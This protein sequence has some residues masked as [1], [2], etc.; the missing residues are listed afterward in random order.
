MNTTSNAI[1]AQATAEGT[2]PATVD[3]TVTAIHLHAQLDNAA[4]GAV[5][6]GKDGKQARESADTR[7][8]RE[9]RQYAA[10]NRLNG[11]QLQALRAG[12]L[13]RES[14]ISAAYDALP[15]DMGT[16]DR[17]TMA[18]GNAISA[19]PTV[20]VT[21]SDNERSFTYPVYLALCTNQQ[22]LRDAAC[23]AIAAQAIAES[24]TQELAPDTATATA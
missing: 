16:L 14:R 15:S 22:K 23:A 8:W 3:A 10:G 17:L 5:A 12:I 13:S 19:L 9:L 24:T 2:V 7:N 6:A 11:R 1:I 4:I 21:K 18:V 20:A